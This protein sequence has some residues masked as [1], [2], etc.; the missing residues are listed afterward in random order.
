MPLREYALCAANIISSN[1]KYQNDKEII[2]T[3]FSETVNYPEKIVARLSVI[4]G[5]YSTQ[6]NK[7]LWGIEEISD[8]I[9]AISQDDNEIIRLSREF[10]NHP[11]DASVILQIITRDYGYK[12]NGQPFGKASS[13]VTKY[14]YFLTNY[15]F[16]IYDSLV[17]SSYRNIRSRPEFSQFNLRRLHDGCNL[18]FFQSV[19]SLNIVS[20]INNYDLLD[21]LLW[22]LGK[23]REGSFSLLFYKNIY[24]RLSQLSNDNNITEEVD[25]KIRNYLQDHLNTPEVQE[26]F[27]DIYNDFSMFFSFCFE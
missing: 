1:T 20:G 4:D 26:L 5:F 19:N 10:I 3:V 12:K 8:S 24:L 17:R 27:G 18:S 14:L 21:N 22:L 7:R 11:T 15:N 6:M 2:K 13:L 9:N 25:L 23:I 16:P